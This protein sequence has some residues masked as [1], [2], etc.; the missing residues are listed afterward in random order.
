MRRFTP[1]VVSSV[2]PFTAANRTEYHFG[3]VAKFFLM[4]A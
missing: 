1:V 4:A 3:S 2:T